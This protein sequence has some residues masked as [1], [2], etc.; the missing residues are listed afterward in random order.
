MTYQDVV[1]ANQTLQINSPTWWRSYAFHFTDVQN[2][3]SILDSGYLYS[4]FDAKKMRLMKTE[5][6]STQVIK[7][8]NPEVYS[9]VRFY[10]RPKTPTQYHNEGY[11]HIKLRYDGHP[12]ANVPVPIFFLFDL[13]K[14]LDMPK[15]K[16]SGTALSGKTITSYKGSPEEFSQLPFERIYS[17]GPMNDPSEVKNRHAEIVYPEKLEIQ[18]CLQFLFCR[19]AVERDTLLNLLREKNPRAYQTYVGKIYVE[20]R[21]DELF[22]NNGLFISNCHWFDGELY[23]EL[24]DTNARK[25]YIINK[26]VSN[27]EPVEFRGEFSWYKKDDLIL[28][29]STYFPLDYMNPQNVKFKLGDKFKENGAVILKT[30]IFFDDKLVCYSTHSLH[31][32]EML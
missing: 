26:N 32:S 22:Y 24:A 28:Q 14:L 11:K 31:E 2:A 20:S 4:R 5:N 1:N 25:K 23:I 27:L 9:F 6:A 15:T 29:Q 21:H 10:F 7:M 16:F 17:N 18:S 13:V 30:K 8:T 12:N 3:V 19:N